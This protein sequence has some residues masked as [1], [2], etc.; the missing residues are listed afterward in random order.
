MSQGKEPSLLEY[1]RHYGLAVNHLEINP[2]EV[3]PPSDDSDLQLDDESIWL[4]FKERAA[5]PKP[6]RLI[7]VKEAS[8]F[9]AATNAK[10]Y[11]D[12][13]F[14]DAD[15]S[16]I[17]RVRD[18]KHELPLL[19]SDHDADM[20]NF[21]HR[22]DPDLE[23]E[24]FPLEKVDDERDEGFG[25]PSSYHDLPELF[26]Q[27][28]Q[29]EKLPMSKDVLA[30]MRSVF[31][32]HPLEGDEPT[33]ENELPT[34]R[35][36]RL[37]DPIT[38]PLLPRSPLLQPYE[39]S[40]ETG[41]LDLLSDRSSPTRQEL[42]KI[43]ELL[44]KQDESNQLERH[45]ELGD[46]DR[47]REVLDLNSAG[48]FYSP[49]KGIGNTPSPQ[50]LQKRSR[51]ED[52]KVEGPLTPPA[53]DRPPPWDIKKVSFSEAMHEIIPNLPPP[54]SEPEGLSPED[55]DM[56]FDE[57]LAPI[58]A[59]V[60][61]EIEQERLQE[62]DTT[63]RVPVPIMDFAKPVPP[64]VVPSSRDAKDWMTRFMCDIKEEYL[65]N[66]KD[67][68]IDRE[69][70][71]TKLSWVPF[72]MSLGRVELQESIEDDG[73]LAAF[74]DQ[75]E[76]VDP[77]TLMWKLPGLRILDDLHESDEEE[78]AYGDFPPAR[79]MQSLVKKRN[80]ELHS[81]EI[82]DDSISSARDRPHPSNVAR[83]GECQS[84]ELSRPAIDRPAPLDEQTAVTS[85]FSAINALDQFL[86]VRRGELREN[87][88]P[89]KVPR[90]QPRPT[91]SSNRPQS[92]DPTIQNIAQKTKLVMPKPQIK[93]PDTPR[94]FVASTSF[95]SNRTL[96]HQIKDL[97]PSAEYIERDFG[98][99]TPQ[100]EVTGFNSVRPRTGSD[101]SLGEAD[102]I[103]SPSTGLILTSLAKIKQQSLPGQ[104]TRSP[105]R[106]RIERTAARYERLIVLVDR[107]S[108][109]SDSSDTSATQNLDE[110][111]CEALTSL[112]AFLNHIP[113]LSE[114]EVILVDG[115]VSVL[116]TWI[117]SLMAKHSS[118][119]SVRLLEDETQWEVFLR[120]AGMNAFAAQVVLAEMKAAKDNERGI[121][122]LR[123]FICMSPEERYRRFE[124]TLGGRA[125]LERVGKVLDAHW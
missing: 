100:I 92:Q 54:I 29:N 24:F 11:E 57:H 65:Q 58:A 21:V 108:P 61:R 39:P 32:V 15:L 60:D 20:L 55:I 3:L 51:R 68:E 23:N 117:V 9:L 118:E 63:S 17:H 80:L 50:R 121:W 56:L 109:L 28:V 27:K 70:E 114:S 37:R 5:S 115:D 40:S 59:K 38:P 75:P 98:L 22:I 42:E 107:T 125:V 104:S 4:H 97:Y 67:W 111:D 71:R 110:S 124:G 26:S 41:H 113:T 46:D 90:L 77:D 43:D 78:L 101:A 62:A 102:L 48:D 94:Y 66:L 7:A 16:Q 31:D 91:D 123:K 112:T 10:L 44:L 36:N 81:E 122:G 82:I 52:L 49:L 106:E 76:A 13:Q 79:D 12:C 105:V 73:S 103:L 93:I 85:G 30:F 8:A 99:Y 25:W 74:I 120:Q 116:A 33:F 19:R 14:E 84:Q 69:T 35:R 119:S 18:L 88:K 89:R 96:T 83:N 86:G 64:W 6:E 2:L 87:H 72:P 47:Q 45:T 53:S 34:Y 1:A 95:F